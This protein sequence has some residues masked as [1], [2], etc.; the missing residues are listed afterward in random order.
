MI[1][2]TQENREALIKDLFRK[3]LDH[4]SVLSTLRLVSEKTRIL[5][6]LSNFSFFFI[7]LIAPV[8]VMYYGLRQMIIPLGICFFLLSIRIS[9]EFYVSH[10]ML[11]PQESED[12]IGNFLKMIL[13]PPVAIRA[14]DVVANNS[15]SGFN[16]LNVSNVLLDKNK[17]SVFAKEFM[18]DLR[19]PIQPSYLS[20][21]GLLIIN[22]HNNTLFDLCKSYLDNVAKLSIDLFSP[23]IETEESSKSYCPRCLSQFTKESGECP[24]CFGV[25]LALFSKSK[26]EIFKSDGLR[27]E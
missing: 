11:F 18:L 2:T 6:I 15:L 12:R 16:P 23:P 9:I 22:W 25:K 19:Y 5:C 14:L 20:D 13:C 10:K 7:F 26:S 1:S 17:Y 21:E 4:E 27:N 8:L 3:T 24:D